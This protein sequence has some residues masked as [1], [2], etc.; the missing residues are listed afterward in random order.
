MRKANYSVFA[1][2]RQII[3]FSEYGISTPEIFFPETPAHQLGFGHCQHKLH[4]RPWFKLLLKT[5][6]GTIKNEKI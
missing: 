4:I 2:E 6:S 5:K 1:S 3:Q